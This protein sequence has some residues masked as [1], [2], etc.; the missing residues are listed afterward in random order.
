[1]RVTLIASDEA[2]A[3]LYRVRILA[4]VLARV[5]EV[6][7]VGFNTQPD[8]T[9]P[10]AP[11]DFPYR[12]VSARRWPLFAAD[13][14]ALARTITG[15]V[16]YAMKARPT[17]LGVALAVGRLTGKPVAV[18]VDDW[19]PYM[20]A[21]F[22]RHAIKNLTY[23]LPRLHDPNAWPYTW[24]ADRLVVAADAVTVVSRFFE[25]LHGG[26][27]LPQ[28]VDTA[29]W[30]PAL[31]PRARAR[32]RFGLGSGPVAAFVGI[33]QPN[34]GTG[35]LLAA[36]Q[37]Q[38]DPDWTLLLAG[39]PTPHALELAAADR[40]VTLTG[41]LAPRDA[42]WAVAAADVVV[43]PQRPEP[44]SAGQ[45]PIKLVEAM[46]MAKP[47]V[48]TAVSDIPE[49][50]ALPQSGSQPRLQPGQEP[51]GWAVPAGDGRTDLLAAAVLNA[52]VNPEAA[53][54]RGMSARKRVQSQFSYEFG[55]GI[56]RALLGELAGKR[57]RDASG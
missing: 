53:L 16:L 40:R 31:F 17:S 34:K 47:V 32:A 5:A 27:W 1:M 41:T 11:R 39:P 37:A 18:D 29:R 57:W 3:P 26:L 35:D 12:Q 9:D 20:V 10:L 6:E 8:Q 15:D 2:T 45:V 21:P 13:A 33:A 25:R 56:L 7:V 49:I 55:A 19:E 48:A 52:L 36:L 51:C 43:L 46:A 22:S 28:L 14:R 4:Q 24:L 38:S 42:P 54:R 30:D 23:S 50:L 44:A